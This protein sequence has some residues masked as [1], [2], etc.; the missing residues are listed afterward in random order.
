MNNKT[1]NL[2]KVVSIITALAVILMD[3]GII[4]NLV[5]YHF[6]VMVIA[7]GLLLFSTR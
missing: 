5:N 4:P 2:L 6:W 7:Y 1:K 3:L